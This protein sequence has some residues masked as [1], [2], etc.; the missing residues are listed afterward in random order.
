MP[1]A[2]KRRRGFALLITITLLAFLVILLVGLA[3]YTRVETAIAGN[4]QRQAQAR[5]NALFALNVAL[6]QLQKHA[7]PDQRVTATGQAA[8]G[9]NAKNFSGVWDA[10]GTG[11]TP[12]TWLVSGSESA[13]ATPDT[14]LAA[15]L[16]PA[17]SATADQE[18]LVGDK[19]VSD[20]AD[21]VKVLKQDI[22]AVGVP[23]QTG[24]P[25][26][27]RYAW[28]V[29][30]QGVKAPV[31]V[32]DASAA[33]DY[34][35]FGDGTSQTDLGRRIRQQIALG[36]GAADASGNPVF[37]PRDANNVPLVASQKITAL[38]QVA[39]LKNASNTQLGLSR[40]QQNFQAWSPTNFAVLANTKLGGLRQDLSLQSGL[41]GS[42]FAAWANYPAYMEK[43]V[44]DAPVTDSEGNIVPPPVPAAPV[45][46][47]PYGGDPLR[48]RYVM[49]PSSPSAGAVHGVAPTL[50]F[51][52]MSFSV[53]ESETAA[54]EMEIAAR[55]VIG[56]WNPYTGALVPEPLKVEVTG[57]PDILVVDNGTVPRPGSHL[58]QLQDLMSGGGPLFFS[59]PWVTDGGDA[60]LATW[61]PGR[62]YD[63]AA[64]ENLTASGSGGI[65]MIAHSPD[66]TPK[67]AGQGIVRPAG[68]SHH[69]SAPDDTDP[70]ARICV[71]LSATPLRVRIL[72]ASNDEELAAYD[73]V[74]PPFGTTP[75]PIA[76]KYVDFAFVARLPQAGEL[77]TGETATW[78]SAARRDPR[79]PSFPANGFISGAKGDDPGAYG[80]TNVVSF[81]VR[82]P[83]R[84]LDRAGN[85][86]SY[87]EDVPLFELPR[88]PLL[89]MGQL[90][91]LQ[92]LDARPFSIGNSWGSDSQVNN[93]RS[94]ELFDRFFFSGLVDG[95]VPSTAP[96]GD[97]ILPNPLLKPVRTWDPT[98]AVPAYRKPTID[99]VRALMSPPT[100]TTTDPDGNE[101]T[102]PIAPASSYSS[103][104][105]LQ[106][107][108]FNLNSLNP[109]AWA[110]VLRGVR[111]PSPQSFTY[112]DASTDTG[113]AGDDS[114]AMVQSGDAQ[115]FRFSQSAQE[116]YKAEAGM[117][118]SSPSASDPSTANTHLFRQG[119]R[120]LSAA[121]VSA[122]AAKIVELVGQKHAAEGPFRSVDEFLSPSALFP[123][124]AI[125]ENTPGASRSLL[126][127]AIADAGINTDVAEF[128]SQWLTQGDVMTALAPVLFP[129]SDTFVIRT[130]GEAVNP[131]TNAT[132]GRAWCEAFVQR[133]PEYFDPN[134]PPETGPGVFDTP[135]NPDDPASTP[136]SGHQLNKAYG[137]RFK[138]LSFRWL[139]RSDI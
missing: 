17:T 31:A 46:Q 105:F 68:F 100:T 4:T 129:R 87:N 62:V 102:T 57:L 82:D 10:T 131:V 50:S 128:S 41:L 49:T 2:R 38:N 47:P 20:R 74:F 37:E 118:D 121:Q 72:R 122:L 44:P 133:L 137:R 124:A 34:A 125:D 3:T 43:L 30:D 65:P 64:P 14:V 8:G 97:L 52:G 103:K 85:S 134:D 113:T 36:A 48:R 67:G 40:I 28:W 13:A 139:T 63:W 138:V 86:F 16:D 81:S 59:L 106:G 109:T 51:F 45:I 84:L 56:L 76:Q 90:Q 88:A 35:P 9:A 39:F 60:D 12:L 15:A 136:T 130:Y 6:G 55:C 73:L 24:T 92:L 104:Y 132:E 27:G 26:I 23:G 75:L 33:V 96:N 111:F 110:A 11:T 71:T 1:W 95:V 80:G 98:L 79:A 25:R 123:G 126:E 69:A 108:A 22:T 91:H 93:I 54:P 120:T 77:P 115:F 61:L 18:F 112:L 5:E 89:S 29:G 32:P 116:T 7:G 94:A 19:T 42:A 127:A 119:M 70:L 107:G 53:R 21:R 78:L 58:V 83:Q 99:D 114:S 101:V 135:S 117:A 66:A